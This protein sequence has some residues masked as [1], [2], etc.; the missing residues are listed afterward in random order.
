MEAAE[1]NRTHDEVAIRTLL[2]RL[3]EA[4]G[5][6]DADAYGDCFTEDATYVTFVGTLYEGRADVTEGHRALFDSFLKGTH[7]ADQIIDIRFYG[8]GTAVVTSRGDTYKGKKPTKLGKTQT[9]TIVREADGHWRI[10]AFHNTKHQALMEAIS[11]KFQ[12]KTRP[13]ADQ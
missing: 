5:H 9:Y 8:P 1:M 3:V 2:G 10:A 11:F 12:P 4:W 7:L 6:G 13:L